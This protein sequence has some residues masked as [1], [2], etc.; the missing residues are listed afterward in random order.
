MLLQTDRAV[1]RRLCGAKLRGPQRGT[2]GA[3]RT[4][5]VL[6]PSCGHS[7]GSRLP[8]QEL[9]TE[10]M[11][12]ASIPAKAFGRKKRKRT[13]K[14]A[15]PRASAAALAAKPILAR[16]YPPLFVF[17]GRSSEAWSSSCIR[18]AP[19]AIRGTMHSPARGLVFSVQSRT[20]ASC[21]RPFSCP[22]PPTRPSFCV[23]RP[24]T[25]RLRLSGG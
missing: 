15:S 9:P 3:K 6:A 20:P 17:F 5:L 10:S 21:D 12:A 25:R 18:G 4:G 23:A 8:A 13:K 2:G 1:L 16:P 11:E 22:R 24:K 7:L 19:E 14:R